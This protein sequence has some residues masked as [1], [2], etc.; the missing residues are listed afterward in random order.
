MRLKLQKQ[1]SCFKKSLRTLCQGGSVVFYAVAF[2]KVPNTD[3]ER[4]N[5]YLMCY[6]IDAIK[7]QACPPYHLLIGQSRYRAMAYEQ[8]GGE[9]G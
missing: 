6:R 2:A 7:A 1:I 8:I 3:S 9:S 5:Y 4:Y